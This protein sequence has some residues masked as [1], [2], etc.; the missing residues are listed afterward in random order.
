MNKYKF[1][2]LL[3]V[4]SAALMFSSCIGDDFIDDVRDPEIRIV[5]K[6]DTIEI[7][8]D[9]Q[10]EAMYLNNVGQVEEVDVIWES[11]NESVATIDHTG[12]LSAVGFGETLIK[13]SYEEG[14]ISL[15]DSLNVFVGMTTVESTDSIFGTIRTTSSYKLTGSFI[16]SEKADKSGLELTFDSD[17]CASSSLP[18]LYIYL[19]NNRNTITEALEMGKVTVFSGEHQYDIPD[20]GINDYSFIVYFCKPFNVKVGDGEI[21]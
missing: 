3:P 6:V 1:G 16:L 21:K 11:F 18:G 5:S 20:V 9:F 2:H 13:V 12:L 7:N 10:M 14:P 4:L 8:T 17:Y 15:T 19:S